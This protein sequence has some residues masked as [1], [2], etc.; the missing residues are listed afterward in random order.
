MFVDVY[1][2]WPSPGP[3]T[4]LRVGNRKP[5]GWIKASDALAW[6]TRLVV[7][8]AGGP[9][10]DCR[11]RRERRVGSAVEVGTGPDSRSSGG[12]K[13]G[14]SRSPTWDL[15]PAV[16]GSVARKGWVRAG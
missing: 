13:K 16:V 5:I 2:T 14:R 4:H 10:D 6:D 1:D 9:V 3:V 15:G 12:I 11:T 8:V 7:R